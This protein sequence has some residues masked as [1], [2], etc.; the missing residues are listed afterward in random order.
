MQCCDSMYFRLWYVYWVLC[1]VRLARCTAP[2]L[3]QYIKHKRRPTT[4]GFPDYGT[5]GVPK[6]VGRKLCIDCVDFG[7]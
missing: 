2:N 3:V 1:S 7:A 4:Q 6:H 5:P